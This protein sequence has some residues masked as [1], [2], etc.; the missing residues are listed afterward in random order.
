MNYSSLIKQQNDMQRRKTNSNTFLNPPKYHLSAKYH[1][2]VL[3]T[4]P[5][6]VIESIIGGRERKPIPA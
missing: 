6:L 2:P 1:I 3:R 5:V 4:G